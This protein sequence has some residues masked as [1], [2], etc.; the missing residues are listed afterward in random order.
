MMN[1]RASMLATLV[2]V[3]TFALGACHVGPQIDEMRMPVSPKGAD[4]LV[5]VRSG[6]AKTENEYR[7]ELLEANDDGLIVALRSDSTNRPQM[8]FVP[9]KIIYSAEATE[10]KGIRV[11]VRVQGQTHD[12]SADKFRLISRFPQGLSPALRDAL[13]ASLEQT[14]VV[15]VSK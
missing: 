14:E 11:R 1:L 2:F 6:G 5:K 13:L 15:L 3:L 7:G 12:D 9:W 8:A 4:V 10:V